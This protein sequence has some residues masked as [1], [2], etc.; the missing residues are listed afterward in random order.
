[1]LQ[2]RSYSGLGAVRLQGEG[3]FIFNFVQPLEDLI[4][5][6]L[7]GRLKFTGLAKLFYQ[8]HQ[9]VIANSCFLQ[10]RILD[11]SNRLYILL[12]AFL[13]EVFLLYSVVFAHSYCGEPL[14]GMVLTVT[15]NCVPLSFD[16]CLPCDACILG[17]SLG[18]FSGFFWSVWSFLGRV[19][20][21]LLD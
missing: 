8:L 14:L 1:M 21:E 6:L 20:Q 15:Y 19:Q 2:K 17:D 5:G 13:I 16:V 7:K 11:T 10:L 9:F 4:K 12:D 3:L 18:V